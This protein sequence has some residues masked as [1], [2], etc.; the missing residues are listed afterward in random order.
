MRE[1]RESRREELTQ[2]GEPVR[3]DAH[4][5]AHDSYSGGLGW[6]SAPAEDEGD[7]LG[8]SLAQGFDRALDFDDF[9]APVYRSL[10]MGGEPMGYVSDG[11]D[12]EVGHEPVYR[13][14]GFDDGAFEADPAVDESLDAEW[15]AT[16]PPLIHRQSARMCF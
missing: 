14:L 2:W 5:S 4:H 7:A 8:Y 11:S 13:S 3:S 10:D 12:F 1:W 6:G 15:L 9:E 16:M